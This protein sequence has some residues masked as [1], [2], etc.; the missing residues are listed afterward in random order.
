MK[1]KRADIACAGH[2][3]RAVSIPTTGSVPAATRDAF[4]FS[5]PL[6]YTTANSCGVVM[7]LHI[8]PADLAD[9]RD[10]DSVVVLLNSYAI[11]PVGG[12]KALPRDV[13]DRLVPAL[14]DIPKALVLLAF[15]DD[16][17]IGIAV[18][19]FGFPTFRA[20]PLLNV[21]DL[22][23]LPQYRGQGVGRALLQ[24]AEDHAR[25]HGCCR[26]TL[27]VLESNF[28]ARGLYRSFGFDDS[29]V[30]RFLVKP[31]DG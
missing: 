20:R 28:G 24:A 6:E 9:A 14:R 2:Q 13:R 7:N 18:C 30:S 21:H 16:A 29:T 5:V 10:A 15:V 11:E 25:R 3:A 26:L 12:G 8:R 17:A 27:E 23:V 22:A 31:L 1:R 4:A 19:F